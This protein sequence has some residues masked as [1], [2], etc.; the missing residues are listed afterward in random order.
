[1]STDD[2]AGRAGWGDI[3]DDSLALYAA[4]T[5]SPEE[6][7]RVEVVMLRYPDVRELVGD[8]RRRGFFV[9]R[10]SRPRPGRRTRCPTATAVMICLAIALL[11]V[12]LPRG[13]GGIATGPIS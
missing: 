6:R 2:D 12:S 7:A 5:C 13:W 8:I 10:R 1:L 3:D 9:P 11:L 4:G